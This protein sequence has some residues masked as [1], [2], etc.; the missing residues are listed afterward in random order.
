MRLVAVSPGCGL[1]S[2]RLGDCFHVQLAAHWASGGEAKTL[3]QLDHVRVAQPLVEVSLSQRRPAR[4]RGLSVFLRRFVT[5]SRDL[6]QEILFPS[7]C[8]LRR[9]N[10]VRPL[11][12]GVQ[13]LIHSG[14]AR[15]RHFAK[16]IVVVPA[17]K[18][19]LHL[20]D[21]ECIQRRVGV[22]CSK[23]FDHLLAPSDRPARG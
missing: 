19:G 6:A 9:A 16:R 2:L 13:R 18:P 8:G 10:H 5:P 17:L 22:F 14:R 12:M 21:S 3:C 11:C 23:F 20:H 1:S 4:S 7:C 15:V